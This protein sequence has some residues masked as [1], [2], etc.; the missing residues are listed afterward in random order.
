MLEIEKDVPL[1]SKGKDGRAT[2]YRFAEMQVG[3]SLFDPKG[4]K[5]L[6]NAACQWARKNGVKF[7][8]RKMDGGVRVWRIE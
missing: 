1:P 3:D 5:G 7:T 4:G 2:K 8:S 6:R